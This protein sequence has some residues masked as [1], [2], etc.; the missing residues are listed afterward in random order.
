MTTFGIHH[1]FETYE[2]THVSGIQMR[3][4]ENV[5][6][7]FSE[8]L[9]FAPREALIHEVP[10]GKTGIQCPQ[11][12]EPK[13]SPGHSRSIRSADLGNLLQRGGPMK[14]K[15]FGLS[16]GAAILVSLAVAPAISAHHS[17][18]AEYD[19]SKPITL[20]GTVVKWEMINPHSYITVE[21]KNDDGSVTRWNVQFGAPSFLY[22]NGW[23]KDSVKPGDELTISGYLAKDGSHT[24]FGQVA[25]LPDGR[26]VLGGPAPNAS[27]TPGDPARLRKNRT[28]RWPVRFTRAKNA[29]FAAALVLIA[30]SPATAQVP[31][32]GG[33]KT[34][35]TSPGTPRY[36]DWPTAT[37][38]FRGFGTMKSAP[39]RCAR[40]D[41]SATTIARASRFRIRTCRSL[42]KIKDYRFTHD[43]YA[44][45]EAH[46]HLPGVPREI[47]QPSGIFP[48]KIIQDQKYIVILFEYTHDVRIIPED[49][50]PH[51]N[52]Y[53][54]WN[55]DSRGHWEGDT[56]VVD[57]ANFNGRTWLDM[58][59]NF[60]D[61][62][63]HVI[64]R[65]TMTDPNSIALAATVEDAD[66]IFKTLDHALDPQEES[67]QGT[68]GGIRLP[69]GR[70]RCGPLSS[71]GRQSIE[72]S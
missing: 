66:R 60:V 61:E 4:E 70:T 68:P 30:M 3:L 50:S 23:R 34:L 65:Y 5:I 56:F 71:L 31:P 40:R 57:V 11:V 53:A 49:G 33:P 36:R 29:I 7:F 27:S 6:P 58:D 22:R 24:A 45:P 52:H 35:R 37:P 16:V 48:F 64:E 42:E 25:H 14:T 26:R 54:A 18:G 15:S 59:A 67:C 28:D 1:T 32:G 19:L 39:R 17:F 63:E 9:S 21:V 55:G 12:W 41:R 47:E 43:L 2:G 44:D 72:Q 46:C 20:H 69:R 51:P 62:N 10:D 13:G 8:N 38:T